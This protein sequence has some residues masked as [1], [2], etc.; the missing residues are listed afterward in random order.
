MLVGSHWAPRRWC[1]GRVAPK[2][3]PLGTAPKVRLGRLGCS[4]PPCSKP[5]SGMGLWRKRQLVR[6]LPRFSFGTN[7][8]FF[9]STRQRGKKSLSGPGEENRKNRCIGALPLPPMCFQLH[10]KRTQVSQS[11]PLNIL[12]LLLTS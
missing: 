10:I 1:R 4:W 5:L 12:F 9:L 2:S 7:T 3:T 6:L 8:Q 11:P